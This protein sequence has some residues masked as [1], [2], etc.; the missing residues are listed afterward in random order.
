MEADP[1]VMVKMRL[2]VEP[3]GI[4]EKHLKDLKYLNFAIFDIF[5]KNHGFYSE[6]SNFIFG[7]K[8]TF[9]VKFPIF[10]IFTIFDK[11]DIL[12]KITQFCEKLKITQFW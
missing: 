1:W 8:I 7:L 9:Y 2:K 5:I 10:D 12:V 11:N 6:Y 3:S 4:K